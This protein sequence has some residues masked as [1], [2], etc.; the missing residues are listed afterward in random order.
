[1]QIIKTDIP[2]ILV[3]EP[4]IYTDDRGYF[5]ETYRHEWLSEVGINHDFVQDNLSR[6]VQ[7]VLRGLHYQIQ[8]A[9]AKLVMVTQGSVLDVAVDIRRGSPTFGRHVTM[10]LSSENRRVMYIPEGFAHG[11]HVISPSADFLYKCS[12]YYD[13]S[14]ERGISWADKQLEIDWGTT[15]PILSPKDQILPELSNVNSEDLPVYHG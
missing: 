5:L 6:S 11:F 12:R 2:E 4:R 13:P 9:Q 1:M 7:G 10:L 8:N 3:V 14:G 15:E